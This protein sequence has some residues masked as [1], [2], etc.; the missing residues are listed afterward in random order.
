MAST[1]KRVQWRAK[2]HFSPS[3]SDAFYS[4]FNLNKE[5]ERYFYLNSYDSYPG[6]GYWQQFDCLERW[7]QRDNLLRSQVVQVTMEN[8]PKITSCCKV[9]SQEHAAWREVCEELI[10]YFLEKHRS[11]EVYFNQ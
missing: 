7:L 10:K 4:Y 5:F 2:H 11:C 1:V 3:P 9:E 8:P 6:F